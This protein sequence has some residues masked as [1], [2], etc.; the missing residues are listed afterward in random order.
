MG[1]DSNTQGKPS[2]SRNFNFAK[3]TK[4]DAVKEFTGG[5]SEFNF[6]IDTS[7]TSDSVYRTPRSQA[8]LDI[9]ASLDMLSVT[10]EEIIEKL[11]DVVDEE[12]LEEFADMSP[13][14][15]LEELRLCFE[16]E[17][18]SREVEVQTLAEPEILIGVLSKCYISGCDLHAI[19]G[20][21]NILEHFSAS[22]KMPKELAVGRILYKQNPG[23]SCIEVYSNCCR[24]IGNDGSVTRVDNDN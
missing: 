14:E 13:E 7:R 24:I 21:G 16:E 22:K 15:L 20:Q 9:I 5:A 6:D 23:C 1:T 17:M 11:K 12:T 10:D 3:D 8:Y 18:L 19:D 4:T 2:G